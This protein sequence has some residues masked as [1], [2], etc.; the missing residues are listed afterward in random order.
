MK[1]SILTSVKKWTLCL[2]SIPLAVCSLMGANSDHI[3]RADTLPSNCYA[4]SDEGNPDMLFIYYKT[5]DTWVE[6]G[7]TDENGIEAIAFNPVNQTLYAVDEDDFGSINLATGEFTAW[8]TDLG[9]ADGALGEEN[10]NDVDG[11]TYDPYLDIFW[12]SH[13]KT[14]STTP[15]FLIQIDPITG[16]HIPDAFGPGVDYVLLDEVYDTEINET[17]YDIDDIA[18]DPQTGLLYGIANQGGEGGMLVIYDKLTGDVNTVVGSFDGID[19]ME[20]LGFFSDGSLFGSTGDNGPDNDDNNKYYRLDKTNGDTIE[21]VVIDPTGDEED[22]EACDCLSE[23]PNYISGDV[24][25]DGSCVCMGLTSYPGMVVDLYYDA[26]GNGIVESGIDYLLDTEIVSLGGTYNFIVTATG[27]F[28]VK[29]DSSTMPTGFSFPGA[30]Q[31]V[32]NFTQLNQTTSGNDFL[33]CSTIEPALSAV[34]CNNNGTSQNGGD[35]FVEVQIDAENDGPGASNKFEVYENG[36]LLNPGGTTYG[37][38]L[39]LDSGEFPILGTNYTIEVRDADLT[40]CTESFEI[41]AIHPCS[42]P[43]R[44]VCLPISFTRQ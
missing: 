14:G 41:Q 35:D 7:S 30:T 44:R 8:P 33:F 18:L 20:G 5:T 39:T 38:T 16:Q 29:I 1:L 24:D 32:F 42:G 11:L 36:M 37:T 26:N 43:C 4:V 31:H 23:Q 21:S 9:D 2:L 12:G 19:D 34:A 28:I 40:G 10:I 15:D 25:L 27:D 17:V 6:I 22:F 13:R 3:I